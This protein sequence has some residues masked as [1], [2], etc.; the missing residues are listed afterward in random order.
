M[1]AAQARLRGLQAASSRVTGVIKKLSLAFGGLFA[2]FGGFL[3]ANIFKQIFGTASQEAIEARQR[4]RSLLVSL[5]QMQEIQKRGKGAAQAE[6]E[7]IYKHNQA[8]EDQG[9]IQKDLLDNMAV[10]LARS[11]IPSKG[12]QEATDKLA[13]L[14]VAVVGV[15]ATEEEA[16]A[17]AQAFAKA[18]SSGK[19]MAL[20]KQGV[21]ITKEQAKEFSKVVGKANR[22][23]ALM[24]ILG[25]NYKNVNNQARN[26]PEGRVQVFRNMIK[27][28]AQDLGEKL[29]PAQA[30]LADAWKAA[31]PELAP[32][33][34]TSMKLILKLVT[35]LG[36]V[37][38]TQLIPWWHEFQKTERFAQLKGILQWMQDHFKGLAITAGVLVGIF[39]GLSVISGILPVIIA[40]ANPVGAIVAGVLALA[41]AVLVVWYNWD[42]IKEM[43][44]A[45]AAVIEHFIEGFKLS[46]QT[47]FDAVI[48]IW[49]TVVALF[50][51]DWQGV[52]DAWKK[53]WGDMVG[54]ATWWQTTLVAIAKAVG[55]AFKDYFLS[56]FEDIKSI[57]TWMKGFSWEGIKKAFSD[58]GIPEDIATGG[59]PYASQQNAARAAKA[60]AP[61]AAAGQGVASTF[62]QLET[63]QACARELSAVQAGNV[64]LIRNPL[65]LSGP[66]G[67]YHY[68]VLS[69]AA[70]AA[71]QAASSQSYAISCLC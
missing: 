53:V 57:W 28:M 50:T 56:V 2:V 65:G 38:R 45:T 15:T 63:Q 49:K 21:D 31:L 51:G 17:M 7:R 69:G 14:L 41:E 58:V 47:G 70:A 59:D 1:T 67:P 36:N 18:V 25:D 34:V 6:L 66:G 3:A 12:I 29:L 61:V 19:V 16:T 42:K 52:G 43:F 8:L 44:P 55:Q 23:N 33:L 26:T 5:N 62:G 30:E 39:A 68:P 4:T 13:D 10:M 9:V 32:L 20:Q 27:N 54:L 37:V 11:H 24:K 71:K 40:L 46:F 35:K 22:F 60:A 48:A 64:N